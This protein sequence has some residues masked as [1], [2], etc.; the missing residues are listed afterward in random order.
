MK[1]VWQILRWVGWGLACLVV[2]AV[3][4]FTFYTH[5]DGFRAFL[6]EQL[7]SAINDSIR[8]KVSVEKIEGSVW[9]SLTLVDVR[10]TNDQTEIV[11]IPRLKVSYALM[12]LVWGHVQVLR[13]AATQPQLQLREGPDGVWNIVAAFAPVEPQSDGPAPVVS[14][15][16]VEVDKGNVEVV[17]GGR[18]YRLAGL[19][20]RG[21]ARIP[22]DGMKV[23]V[24]RISAALLAE[25]F[26]ESRLQGDV[27]YEDSG[28]RESISFSDFAL[29][30]GGSRLT[31]GGKIA[32]LETLETNAKL[33]IDKL[34]PED[35]ARFVPE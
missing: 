23:D 4:A 25:G 26:P 32:D 10:I 18:S 21:S 11:A 2:L 27:I 35:I 20:L 24:A 30:T 6:R 19:D 8:G 1:K 31:V 28:G 7:V 34:A 3:V 5:T 13:A 16:S 15:R 9:G 12:P 14:I 29:A 22:P 17:F 33:A